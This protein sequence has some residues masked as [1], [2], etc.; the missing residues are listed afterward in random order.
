MLTEKL[1][2]SVGK[3]HILHQLVQSSAHKN[4][5]AQFI[6]HNSKI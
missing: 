6:V 4:K 2:D 3:V 1:I 5:L